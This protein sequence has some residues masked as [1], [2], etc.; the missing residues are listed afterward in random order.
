MRSV[1][2]RGP[3]LQV[4]ENK[5]REKCLGLIGMNYCGVL[6]DGSYPVAARSKAWDCGLS[7]AGI[8]GSNPIGGIDICLSLL[9][10]V[11]S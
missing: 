9:L 2:E 6:Y 1:Y 11:V 7:L 5:V 4:F 8:V 3:K 10:C